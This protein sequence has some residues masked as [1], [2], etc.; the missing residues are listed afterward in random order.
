MKFRNMKLMIGMRFYTFISE[1]EFNIF[2]LVKISEHEGY[3]MNE[4]TL[5]IITI[6][7]TELDKS[8]ILLNDYDSWVICNF[9]P[10]EEFSEDPTYKNTNIWITNKFISGFLNNRY[11]SYPY[12]ITCVIRMVIYNF[13]TKTV[14]NKL[15]NYIIQLNQDTIKVFDTS[16]ALEHIWNEYFRTI[17]DK[18]CILH[19]T[20]VK[21]LKDSMHYYDY[22]ENYDK[23]L[24]V[25]NIDI[26]LEKIVNSD[27]KRI[28]DIIINDA[29][30]LLDTFILTYEIYAYDES[31]NMNN[32][33]MKHFFIYNNDKYYLVLYVVDQMKEL[34]STFNN[35]Q[36][37][38]D[39]VDFML[40]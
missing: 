40:K 6:T 14:F 36:N 30:K 29:E 25:I 4:E 38:K 5:E 21:P 19:C 8:Y 23:L 10:K 17:N 39:I 32:V 13:M 7:E 12:E 3:F 2:S 27:D 20:K 35:L 33:N 11:M 34:D 22:I 37:H 31:I 15:I 28:P 18:Y 1:N 9:T 26:D 24:N 16:D